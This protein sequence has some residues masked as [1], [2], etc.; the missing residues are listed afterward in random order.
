MKTH[1]VEQRSKEWHV[2]RAGK[3]TASGFSKMLT[4]K[5]EPSKSME[6]YAHSLAAE[7]FSGKPE[8]DAWEGN[9]FSERGKVLEEEAITWYEFTRDETVVPVGFVTNDEETLGCSPDGLIGN[10]GL[11]EVKCLKAE[12]HIEVVL[13]H[14]KH[15]KCPTSYFQQTQGQMLICERKWCDI[16]FYHPDLPSLI[17]RQEPD[18]AFH[19]AI[20][21]QAN[22]TIAARN[23]I[24]KTLQGVSS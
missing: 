23:D 21:R 8:L 9:Q 14:K 6:G 2:L 18:F 3:P 16:L 1:D 11:I 15:G 10:D 12:R 4:S 24:L 22:A 7:L 13:Y 17:I 19:A 20:I 5:G